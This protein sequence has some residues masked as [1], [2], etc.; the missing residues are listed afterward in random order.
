MNPTAFSLRT[1]SAQVTTSMVN[2]TLGSVNARSELARGLRSI[3]ISGRGC[4]QLQGVDV[5]DECAGEPKIAPI[6]TK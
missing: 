1:T 3:P 2:L 6:G 4:D 5:L